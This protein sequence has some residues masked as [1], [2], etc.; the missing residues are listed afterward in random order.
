[1]RLENGEQKP[2]RE[3]NIPQEQKP[4]DGYEGVWMNMERRLW[5]WN[6]GCGR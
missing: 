3:K 2:Q 6:A 1:M 4:Q 5:D